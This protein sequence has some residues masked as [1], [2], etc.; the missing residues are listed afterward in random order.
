[1]DIDGQGYSPEKS[2]WDDMRE[3]IETDETCAVQ[4]ARS[5]LLRHYGSH[6]RLDGF[7]SLVAASGGRFGWDLFVQIWPD[8][9]ASWLHQEA[10]KKLARSQ[11]R[12]IE[13]M[14]ESN[15]AFFASL[16]DEFAIYRGCS[17]SRIGGLSWSTDRDVATT[18]ANGHRG[19]IVNNPVIGS[20]KIRKA[21]VL[22]VF[23]ERK[24]S[25]VLCIPAFIN[26]EPFK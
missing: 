6:N 25:E 17:K 21:D 12:R 14:S 26:V 19:I 23:T 4:Q 3:V 5:C 13:A 16:P 10:I 7:F 1:M 9:D 20:A 8:C 22:A 24:E 18:F 15:Q 2:R 11:S